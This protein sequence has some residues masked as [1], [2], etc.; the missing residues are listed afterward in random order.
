MKNTCPW[1][2]PPTCGAGVSRAR[3]QE[4]RCLAHTPSEPGSL[5]NRA[6]HFL[7]SPSWQQERAMTE[8]FGETNSLTLQQAWEAE[9]TSRPPHFTEVDVGS[10][11]FGDIPQI[12]ELTTEKNSKLE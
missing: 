11:R 10:E 5:Q 7:R 9:V 2:L 6:N 12:T 3:T 1:A 4:T 8:H